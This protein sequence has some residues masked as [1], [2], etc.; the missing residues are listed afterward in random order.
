MNMKTK[1]VLAY[2]DNDSFY[3]KQHHSRHIS[4]FMGFYTKL[5]YTF[6]LTE[7]P[8]ISESFVETE[9]KYKTLFGNMRSYTKKTKVFYLE[10]PRV[11]TEDELNFWRMF[12]LG[13]LC[14]LCSTQ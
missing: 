10:F 11:L 13:Y 5:G 9:V 7:L 1:L 4:S 14:S 6:P 2:I 8:I 12:K 3:N